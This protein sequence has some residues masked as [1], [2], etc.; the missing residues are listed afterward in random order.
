MIDYMDYTS[1]F[2]MKQELS[3]VVVFVAIILADLFLP[4]RR[5]N[6][7]MYISCALLTL[8]LVVSAIPADVTLFGGMYHSTPITSLMKSVL[9]IGTIL[10]LLQSERWIRR[11]DTRHKA[12]E[13]YTLVVS[14]LI[15]MYF[16]VSAGHF[17]LF[18]LGL[19]LATVPMACLVAFD[20]YKGHSAEAGAKFILSALFS[21]G[22][23]LYGI[24][25]IYGTVGTLYFEDIPAGLTGSP[26]QILALVFIFAGM[27]FKLSLV[28]FHL[29]TADTYQ[30]APTAVSGYLS[31][32]SKGAAAF[33]LMS[34]LIHV[35]APMREE[36]SLMISVVIVVTI[37]IANL[38]AMRQ[39]NLKRFMAFS[40]VSQA[41]YIM[42]AVVA[43]NAQG[44]TSLIYYIVVYIVANLAVFGCISA[45]EQHSHGCMEREDYNGLYATNPRI[46]MVMTLA[47]FS[48]AG[49]PPF[50]GFFSKFFVFAA[51]FNGG[52][53]LIVFIALVNTIISLYYY[54]LI[55]KAIFITPNDKPIEPFK[56]TATMRISLILCIAGI[57]LLGLCSGVYQA[58][59]DTAAL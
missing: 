30:G 24:S 33:A 13:F 40:S 42:L 54:L 34:M 5:R 26:L 47:L 19:E 15:G 59:S 50:A 37:T 32:I 21:S 35:F 43:G 3:L 44:M 6:L 58:I 7:L 25:M 17:L 18:F 41:G 31:V 52:F 45:V 23:F 22:I 48:L 11:G 10:L 38:F 56:T 20:K 4:E 12:G 2:Q 39:S 9:T 29:W 49:I 51:A 8:Q 28:P 55:V 14:T 57:I 53:T 27:G 16:M 36:W 1:I 46:S